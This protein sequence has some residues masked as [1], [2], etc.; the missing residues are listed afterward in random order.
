M[1]QLFKTY[2]ANK[3]IDVLSLRF[4]LDGEPI[5]FDET[6]ASLALQ[7]GDR[8]DCMLEQVGC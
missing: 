3:G 5:P 4:H 2:A 1:G 6:P 7:D 8:I